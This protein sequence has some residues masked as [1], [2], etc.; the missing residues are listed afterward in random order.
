M[1][2]RITNHY[3]FSVLGPAYATCTCNWCVCV[4]VCG[5]KAMNKGQFKANYTTQNTGRQYNNIGLH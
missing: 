5:G 2:D 4:C 3:K 1:Y